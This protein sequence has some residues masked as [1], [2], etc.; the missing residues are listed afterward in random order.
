V[1]FGSTAD[2]VSGPIWQ[3]RGLTEEREMTRDLKDPPHVRRHVGLSIFAAVIALSAYLGCVGLASGWLT[4]DDTVVA[5][6]PFGSPVVGGLALA[7]VVGAPTTWLAWLAWRGDTRTDTA[8]FLSGVLLTG[9]ILVELAIIREFSF[10]HPIYLAVG[11]IL[12]WVG[13]RGAHELPRLLQ[14]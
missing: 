3:L 8:A 9:W 2:V 10:F 7:L 14:R 5:R 12:T 13:R 1:T 6:L 11:V 4:L